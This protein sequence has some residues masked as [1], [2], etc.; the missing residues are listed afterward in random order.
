MWACPGA[1]SIPHLLLAL[2][3]RGRT[4]DETSR[5]LCALWM[6][7]APLRCRFRDAPGTS[8]TG[9]FWKAWPQ[10]HFKVQMTRKSALGESL[11]GDHGDRAMP[12]APQEEMGEQQGFL[13]LKFTKAGLPLLPYVTC[14]R[15]LLTKHCRFLPAD[16]T[17]SLTPVTLPATHLHPGG[18]TG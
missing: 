16:F 9:L 6:G 1:P 10:W 3:T 18:S 4:G 5:R 14:Q 13:A 12:S 7:L 2:P 17:Q 8:R 11:G 15:T